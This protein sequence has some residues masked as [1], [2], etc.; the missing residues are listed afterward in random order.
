MEDNIYSK[1][2]EEL[3]R[4]MIKNEVNNK[5]NKQQD[6]K[7][8]SKWDFY[9]EKYNNFIKFL[10][11]N[12]SEKSKL[13]DSYLMHR[14]TNP[15]VFLQICTV[16]LLHRMDEIPK[17]VDEILDQYEENRSMYKPEIMSKLEQYLLFFCKFIKFA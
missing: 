1:L 17:Y 6:I 7:L 10:D 12:I 16:N 14:N 11:S 2:D 4:I 3:D 5:N 9:V 8:P 15:V 13:R